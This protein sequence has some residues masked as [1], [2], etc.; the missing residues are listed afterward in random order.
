[1]NEK[2]FKKMIDFSVYAASVKSEM[3]KETANL[4]KEMRTIKI[5]IEAERVSLRR[6]LWGKISLCLRKIDL[7]IS[8]DNHNQDL[9]DLMFQGRNKYLALLCSSNTYNIYPPQE[10]RITSSHQLLSTNT[11]AGIVDVYYQEQLV[12]QSQW[13]L[14]WLD[15]RLFFEVTSPL[16]VSRQIAALHWRYYPQLSFL[17]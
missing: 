6:N 10:I 14:T 9:S 15:G 2:N 1:M 16:P 3:E 7:K 13:R 8:G 17:P 12:I 4:W 11:V 5:E